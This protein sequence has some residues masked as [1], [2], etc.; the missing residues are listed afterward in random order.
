MQVVVKLIEILLFLHLDRA[1]CLS[2]NIIKALFLDSIVTSAIYLTKLRDNVVSA[3]DDLFSSEEYML[4]L[5]E[6]RTTTLSTR[7]IF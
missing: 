2:T 3:L 7:D 5:A 1:V 4:L 6:R